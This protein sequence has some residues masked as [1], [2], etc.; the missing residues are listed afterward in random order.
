VRHGGPRFDP[1]VPRGG[2][3]WW[4][5]DAL[6]DDGR[7]GLTV[8][9]FIGSVFSPYYAW[10]RRRGT[11]EPLNF[12]AMNVVLYGPGRKRWAMT[13][14]GRG[15][16]AQA[17]DSLRIGPSEMTWDGNVLRFDLD[18]VTA[19]LPSRIRGTIRVTPPC[20][21]NH[22]FELDAGGHHRWRVIGPG[23][24]VEVTL[25]Q[26]DLRW[27]GTGYL[28]TNDGDEPMETRFGTWN[29]SRAPLHDGTAV[30]Y[31]VIGRDGASRSLALRYD[32]AGGVEHFDA[33]ATRALK[34]GL[35]GVQRATRATSGFTP[36]VAQTLEDAPFYTRSVLNTH[37]LGEQVTAMHESLSLDRFRAPWVQAMLPFKM[38]RRL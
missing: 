35:W 6:S 24:H 18:E 23:A 33:P 19:P 17:P 22:T 25:R 36:T 28:D 7:C 26:P 37:L 3:A 29:W 31:D 9:A 1:T 4:Y 8:I 21:A 27:R 10:S 32:R 20:I 2:Y 5:V 16:I 14:R 30:L 38:P 15:A 11:A 12:C 34:P 13:E